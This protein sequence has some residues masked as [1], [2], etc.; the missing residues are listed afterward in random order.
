[1]HPTG[2][3]ELPPD[4]DLVRL[5]DRVVELAIDGDLVT[6]PHVERGARRLADAL[7]T[8]GAKPRLVVLPHTP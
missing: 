4:F 6:N 8:R 5:E 1:M 3:R 2:S 7:R